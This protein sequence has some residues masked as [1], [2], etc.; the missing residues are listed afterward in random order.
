VIQGV[1]FDLDGTLFDGPYDWPAI[2]R[3]LGL[4]PTDSTILEHFAGLPPAERARKERAL[5]EIEAR[6]TREGR[7][8]AG[9]AELLDF[10]R[11]KGLKLALVTNNHRECAD[12][13]LD[14][15]RLRF[16]FVQTRESGL[17]KPTGAALLR[18]ANEIGLPP[19]QIAAVGD[20]ELDNRAAHEA[21]MRPV[22]IVNREVRRFAGRCDHALRD[23]AELR[24]LFERLL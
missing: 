10:L 1:I 8:K 6:A 21:G 13:I 14:R 15:Y 12:E 19:G 17:F 4:S 22:I 9:A 11:G 7:L 23:L 3:T 2:K 16:D 20:N 24:D 5:R 18:A